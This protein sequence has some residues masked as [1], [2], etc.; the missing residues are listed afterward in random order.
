MKKLFLLVGLF[1]VMSCSKEEI[2]VE[3][4]TLQIPQR[5]TG[6]WINGNYREAT[7]TLNSLI[8]ETQDFGTQKRTKGIV[9][10]DNGD[11][12]YEADLENGEHLTLLYRANNTSIIEDDVIGITLT[13]EGKMY[14][15]S[16]FSRQ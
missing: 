4:N 6:D 14:V 3:E 9:T 8:V 12:L 13:S 7:L 11:T 16:S 1:L 5:F 15:S 10:K 2:P